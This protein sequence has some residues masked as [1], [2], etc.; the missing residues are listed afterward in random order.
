MPLPSDYND[1]VQSLSQ[2]FKDPI[3]RLGSIAERDNLGLPIP[4]SGNFACV[5]KVRAAGSLWA[6]RF[7]IHITPKTKARY[8]AI[9]IF[10]KTTPCNFFVE[11]D[12]QEDAVLVGGKWYPMVK[13]P[14]I[15]GHTLDRFVRENISNPVV[16]MAVAN[17]FASIVMQM[18]K[19]NVAHGDLQHGNIIITSNGIKLIDYD[20]LFCS[21]TKSMETNEIGM[22]NY[23]HP[24]RRAV[25]VCENIDDFSAWIIF[26]SLQILSK[27]KSYFNDN[28]SLIFEKS[29]FEFPK[30]SN[31]I[32][33]IT[34]HGNAEIRALG[35]FLVNS[36]LV[37]NVA[38][39]PRFS[40]SMNPVAVG[41]SQIPQES[42]W[43]DEKSKPSPSE[44]LENSEW[45]G[46]WLKKNIVLC[47]LL[48]LIF[49]VVFWM[50][51][52]KSKRNSEVFS[53]MA[54][55]DTGF[56]YVVKYTSLNV[57]SEPGRRV[58]NQPIYV[59]REGETVCFTG[60]MKIHWEKSSN[61]SP[62]IEVVPLEN[63]KIKG[64]VNRCRLGGRV[65]GHDFDDEC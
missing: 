37:S 5:Y 18:K 20:G 33:S 12:F 23:Q 62:W 41:S 57:R 11:F 15:N 52:D 44:K 17:D 16:I 35:G 27:D 32:K 40:L 19:L 63:D 43:I 4:Y 60:K 7:F 29:D 48:F 22:P 55:C 14:W 47:G 26:I 9:K 49:I 1:A 6:L 51:R 3:I 46:G 53:A 45:V 36:L 39:V 65:I 42:W 30:K 61:K 56:L 31:R 28:D 54:Q 59:L 13:M 64:W 10:F 34:K 21:A 50:G 24:K 25:D 58:E 38:S 2:K 8:K